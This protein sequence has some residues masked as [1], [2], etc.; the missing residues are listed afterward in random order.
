M[1]KAKKEIVS[2]P[3]D[4][5]QGSNDNDEFEQLLKDWEAIT[6]ELMSKLNDSKFKVSR[7]RGPKALMALGA[8][9]VHINMAVQAFKASKTNE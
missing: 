8:M 7:N 4:V 1:I 5:S 9:E 3:G 2:N 6:K